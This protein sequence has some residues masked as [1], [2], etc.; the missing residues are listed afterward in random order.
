MGFHQLSLTWY[1]SCSHSRAQ[2]ILTVLEVSSLSLTT[3]CED[4]PDI[5]IQLMKTQWARAL[6]TGVY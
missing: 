2:G 5:N 1:L 4:Y 6:K 3:N